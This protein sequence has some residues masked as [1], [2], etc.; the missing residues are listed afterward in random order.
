MQK[1]YIHLKQLGGDVKQRKLLAHCRIIL[2]KSRDETELRGNSK[3]RL[4]K[5][6]K[7]RKREDGYNAQRGKQRATTLPKVSTTKAARP[8]SAAGFTP[9][10]QKLKKDDDNED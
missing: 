9:Q 10:P 6:L 5:F 8:S 3:E 2:F 7:D 4:L 1:L